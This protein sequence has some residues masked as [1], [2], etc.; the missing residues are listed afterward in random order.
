MNTPFLLYGSYGYTGS[1]IADLAFRLGMKPVLAG[2]DATRLKSQADKFGFEY[3]PL[4][5][6]EPASLENTLSKLPLVLNCAG[7]FRS[8]YKP[9]VQACL[10]TGKHYLDITGEIIVFESLV[11][12]DEAA[13]QAGVMLLPGI[14]FDVAPSDC[15]AR[16]LKGRLPGAT[17]LTLAI[18]SLGGGLSRG[19]AMTGI[20]GISKPGLVRK[21]GKLVEVPL[22]WKDLQVDFGNG[23]RTVVS[24]PWADVC[25]AYYSSGIPNIEEYMGFKRSYIKVA[26]L[27]KP[28]IGLA[29]K[30]F[31]QRWLKQWIMNSP[32]G[33]SEEARQRGR[34]R[35]WGK[36]TDGQAHTAISRLETPEGYTLT[37]A[38]ALGAVR[39]VLQ[40]DYK[41]GSQ[42]PSMAYGA[43]FILEFDGV[44]REDII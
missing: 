4:S 29:G 22:F 17:H 7:P 33:P 37:A 3:L 43:D 19:T 32:P 26:R 13:R 25:T 36:V 39:H 27:L 18:S 44:K 1:L 20:E 2:R 42:T 5:L 6:D 15:L 34:S 41:P 14:G 28:F 12:Q 31:V 16:H 9:M 21:E 23:P 35:L 10:R 30:P 40:G 8:T 11:A 38:T 24:F